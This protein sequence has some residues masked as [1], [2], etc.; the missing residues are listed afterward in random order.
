MSL[1]MLAKGLREEVEWTCE[2]KDELVEV[3]AEGGEKVRGGRVGRERAEESVSDLRKGD[4]VSLRFAGA[5][6]PPIPPPL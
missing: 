5:C 3:G 2:E 6:P 1:A 4:G